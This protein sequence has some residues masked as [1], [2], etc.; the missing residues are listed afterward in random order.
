VPDLVSSP[1]TLVPGQQR[2]IVFDDVTSAVAGV[3]HLYVLA[4]IEDTSEESNESNNAAGP[5]VL[6][7]GGVPEVRVIAPNGGEKWQAGKTRQIKWATYGVIAGEPVSIFYSTNGG[8]IWSTVAVNE[9]DDGAYDWT[10]PSVNSAACL[11]R[12][13]SSGGPYEDS[14]DEAFTIYTTGGSMPNLEIVSIDPSDTNPDGTQAIDVDV[15]V[16][17]SGDV[18][19]GLFFVD[20]FFDRSQAPEVGE[21]GDL[22]QSFSGL[23]RSGLPGDSHTFTFTGITSASAGSWSMYAIV[24]TQGYVEESDEADNVSGPVAIV[25]R[26]VWVVSPAPGDA[27]EHGT[28]ATVRWTSTLAPADLVNIEVSV[29]DG[30]TWSPVATGIPNSGTYEWQIDCGVSEDCLMRVASQDGSASGATAGTFAV[31]LPEDLLGGGCGGGAAG[32]S[33]S[34]PAFLVCVVVLLVARRRLQAGP[35][36]R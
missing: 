13:V 20:L 23:A 9:P 25:W 8:G 1:Q 27:L 22:P 5:A 34:A 17:N 28:G 15:T 4:D 16:R 31:R 6:N 3:W 7:W 24:D 26:R 18:D 2:Q 30:G 32:V 21:L 35:K 19:S 12:V 11:A 33:P 10:V 14:S 36:R 29:D